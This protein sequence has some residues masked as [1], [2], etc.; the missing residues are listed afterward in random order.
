ML[1]IF[2]A[3]KWVKLWHTHTHTHAHACS[4]THI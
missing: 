3:M 2:P 1:A 4:R